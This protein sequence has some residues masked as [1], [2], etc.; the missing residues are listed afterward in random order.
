M[1]LLMML[2]ADLDVAINTYLLDNANALFIFPGMLISCFFI[3]LTVAVYAWLPELR[4]L[5]GMVLMAYL[6]SFF[7]GFLFLAT[8]QILILNKQITQD[9]CT[10]FCKYL[11][12]FLF[13][14][15]QLI[16]KKNEVFPFEHLLYGHQC[17][18]PPIRLIAWWSMDWCPKIRCSSRNT[19]KESLATSIEETKELNT[20]TSRV[21]QLR[22]FR[23]Y[24]KTRQHFSGRKP[25]RH[26]TVW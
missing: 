11:F 14:F 22:G 13:S 16:S 2:P 4:N 24:R 8:M 6:L 20:S 17:I 18:E 1:L 9:M 23:T 5:H 10:V 7:V 15:H 26:D 12:S 25:T 19:S 3:L 21:N